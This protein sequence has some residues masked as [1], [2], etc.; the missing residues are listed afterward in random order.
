MLDKI[1]L[2]LVVAWAITHLRLEAQTLANMAVLKGLAPVT[3]LGTRP[4]ARRF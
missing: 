3:A 1:A 2:G 4:L